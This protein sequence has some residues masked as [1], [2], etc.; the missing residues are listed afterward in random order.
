MFY[1]H[2]LDLALISD[3]NKYTYLTFTDSTYNVINHCFDLS[4]KSILYDYMIQDF[5]KSQ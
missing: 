3:Y 1:S 4:Q 5:Y 2:F